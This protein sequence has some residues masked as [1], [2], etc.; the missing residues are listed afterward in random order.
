MSFVRKL[1][2]QHLCTHQPIHP[3][4]HKRQGS[5]KSQLL[6]RDLANGC[7]LDCVCKK[8]LNPHLLC[9]NWH[10][11]HPSQKRVKDERNEWQ[12]TKPMR[13]PPARAQIKSTEKDVHNS[14]DQVVRMIDSKD[15]LQTK[16][17]G[18]KKF[19]AQ[20]H[21]YSLQQQHY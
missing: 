9:P 11:F 8:Q 10:Q 6:E 19:F 15:L 14:K 13:P 21:L 16:K 12:T 2:F 7:S 18:K 17:Y 3:R 5:R 1:S 4:N 20:Q